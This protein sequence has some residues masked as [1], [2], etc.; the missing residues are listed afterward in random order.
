MSS[1][2][3]LQQGVCQTNVHKWFQESSVHLF[4]DTCLFATAKGEERQSWFLEDSSNCKRWRTVV[5]HGRLTRPHTHFFRGLTCR[6]T[7]ISF[8]WYLLLHDY[9][10]WPNCCCRVIQ[11]RVFVSVRTHFFRG[12]TNRL[13]SEHLH[14]CSLIRIAEIGR[15][16]VSSDTRSQQQQCPHWMLS[17]CAARREVTREREETERD[18]LGQPE[19]FLIYLLTGSHTG[20]EVNWTRDRS[21]GC[22]LG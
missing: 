15:I 7:C 6:K 18:W 22:L 1:S 11:V 8:C 9:K 16:S 19:L 2:S 14:L 17:L 10:W 12:S 4:I 21:R 5:V 20:E 3:S 13:E